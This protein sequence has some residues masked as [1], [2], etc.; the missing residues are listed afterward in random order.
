[1]F[2]RDGRAYKWENRARRF[3]SDYGRNRSDSTS[4]SIDFKRVRFTVEE[5]R[6][7][8]I[9]H[10]LLEK[11]ELKQLALCLDYSLHSPFLVL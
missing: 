2:F 3:R 9:L 7:I 1:M 6:A 11:N 4:S 10:E 8:G 5:Y